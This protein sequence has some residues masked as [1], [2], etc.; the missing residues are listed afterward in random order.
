MMLYIYIGTGGA[1]KGKRRDQ[2]TG[3]VGC[4]GEDGIDG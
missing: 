2:L 3:K 1:D 4:V